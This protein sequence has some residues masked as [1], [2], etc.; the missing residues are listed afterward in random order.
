MEID[1]RAPQYKDGQGATQ[2]PQL[3]RNQFAWRQIVPGPLR[4]IFSYRGHPNC[5]RMQKWNGFQLILRSQECP[6]ESRVDLTR[7]YKCACGGE[8]GISIKWVRGPPGIGVP[9]SHCWL[10]QVPEQLSCCTGRTCG[11]TP[12]VC[13]CKRCTDP[14]VWHVLYHFQATYTIN[15]TSCRVFPGRTVTLR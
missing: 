6:G 14:I 8:G 7:P 13:V 12:G 4:R 5:P 11:Y 10:L 1:K 3:P 9:K 2:E 15:W